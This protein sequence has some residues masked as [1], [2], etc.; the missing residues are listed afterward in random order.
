ML[1]NTIILFF[2]DAL[3]IFV[4]STILLSILQRKGITHHWYY[5]AVLTSI[6]LSLM[7]LNTIGELSHLLDDTGREWFYA[8]CYIF[9]YAVSLLLLSQQDKLD[10]Q[11]TVKSLTILRLCAG[12]LVV[13]VMALNGANFLIYLTGF[14]SQNNAS[15]VLIT[16]VVLGIGICVSIAVLLYFFMAFI[17]NYFRMFRET[18]LIF[19]SAGLLMRAT[20]LLIQIDAFPS[21]NF[22]WDSNH[23]I[24]EDSEIGQLLTAFFGYDATPTLLQLALY[25]LAIVMAFSLL[26]VRTSFFSNIQNKRQNQNQIK[27]KKLATHKEAV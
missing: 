16:G 26:Y 11:N 21:N 19:F 14:W 5:F 12:V 7:L 1:I 15:D 22:L 8:S 9:C 24:L 25:I 27:N 20:N 4:L 6:G 23:V 17:N 2:R 18:M 10:S 13:T 3:P